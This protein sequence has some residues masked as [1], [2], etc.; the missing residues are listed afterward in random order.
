MG[1]W[2]ILPFHASWILKRQ[3]MFFFSFLYATI[4]FFF[5]LVCSFGNCK[6]FISLDLYC[7]TYDI[8]RKSG[9]QSRG[10]HSLS[11]FPYQWIYLIFHGKSMLCLQNV[12][13]K[14]WRVKCESYLEWV[15]SYK[16]DTHLLIM[17]MVQI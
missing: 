17:V 6:N 13:N 14:F 3:A 2:A 12:L 4:P 8:F 15:S 10:S 1:N 16:L 11:S 7:K 5:F 9:P